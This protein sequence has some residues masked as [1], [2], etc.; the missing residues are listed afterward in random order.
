MR[1]Q[2]A[3]P[4]ARQREAGWGEVVAQAKGQ[5]RGPCTRRR[6]TASRRNRPHEH[7]HGPETASAVC[8][9]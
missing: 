7:A 3:R 8:V 5:G 6:R 4:Y 2:N 1:A 9:P